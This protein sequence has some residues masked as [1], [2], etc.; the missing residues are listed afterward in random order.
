[1]GSTQQF[2]AVGNFTFAAGGSSDLDVSSQVTWNSSN[3]GA[4]TIDN[5]GN[6][7]TVAPG[8]TTIS[9]TSCDGI[10]SGSATLI[11]TPVAPQT[12]KITPAAPTIAT[13]TTTLFTALELLSDGTTQPLQGTITWTSGTTTTA[14]IDANSGIALG[15]AVGTST[16]TATESGTGFT[17]TATLTV[18]AAAAR[19]AYIANKQGNGVG[20]ALGLGPS[21][22]TQSM[23][24]PALSQR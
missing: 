7:T 5:S 6:T 1:M 12:L 13:G 20:G 4:A 9:A 18:Q 14:T 15:I 11:V 10:T 17:G 2:F 21:P 16:I 24:L 3:P 19:F 8:T 23:H 22:S